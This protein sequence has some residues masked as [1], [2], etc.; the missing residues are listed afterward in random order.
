MAILINGTI[1]AQKINEKTAKEVADLRKKGIIPK[2]GIILVGK[3]KA[4]LSYVR[5]KG[6]KA[7]ESG[8]DFALYEFGDTIT[9]EELLAK[10]NEITG[11]GLLTGLI[12][13]LP[14]PAHIHTRTVLQAVPP[15]IDVDCLTEENL[16]KL[17]VKT[18][19]L[20]PPTAGAV[21]S[22]LK[23]LR[24]DL[25][26]SEITIVGT[27]LLVGKPL[28]IML[29]NENASVTTCNIY[30]KDIK[31]RC[32]SSKI[33]ITG[34]GK[35]D[36]IRADMVCEGAIV[37]SAGVEFVEGRAHGDICMEEMLKE[38]AYVTPTPGGIGPITV[39]RLLENTVLCAQR[40]L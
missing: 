33:I 36:L 21:M 5:R 40:D 3:D 6:E 12:V 38:A 35:K 30:T 28:V 22:I 39:A 17:V 10:M 37:I 14:L 4:S 27:G 11:E 31:A 29:M 16:G 2:L 25:V 34:V 20:V 8:I 7:K 15:K 24:V 13:Q 32:L 23:N 18:N 9:Q 26:G 19:Y 1:I